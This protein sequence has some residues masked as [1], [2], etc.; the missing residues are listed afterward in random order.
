MAR[1]ENVRYIVFVNGEIEMDTNDRDEAMQHAHL[2]V[3]EKIGDHHRHDLPVKVTP[4]IVREM[5]VRVSRVRESDCLELPLQLWF[6]DYY[7]EQRQCEVEEENREWRRYL[8]LCEKFRDRIAASG[9]E[10]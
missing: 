7:N 8:E 3:D 9:K 2:R 1:E 10:S 4:Q 6:D 5:D